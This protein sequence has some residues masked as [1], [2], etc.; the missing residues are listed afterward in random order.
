[1]SL[2]AARISVSNLHKCTPDRFSKTIEKLHSYVLPQTGEN[3]PLISD[4]VY[5]IVME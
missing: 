5:R 2:L 1:M 4:E 3:S